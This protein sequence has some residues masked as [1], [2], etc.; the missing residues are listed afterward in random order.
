MSQTSNKII[1]LPVTFGTPQQKVD[2]SV[3]GSWNTTKELSLDEYVELHKL[4][5]TVGW[6]AYS[7][8]REIEV[9]DIPIVP[10]QVDTGAGEKSPS[11]RLRGVIYKHWELN[12]DRKEPFRVYYERFMDNIINSIKKNLP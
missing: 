6:L 7:P 3:R 2:N 5:N 12:T 1:T 4:R 11:Q 9:E 8:S 10:I